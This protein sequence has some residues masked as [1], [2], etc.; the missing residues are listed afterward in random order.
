M[1]TVGLEA[2]ATALT[3]SWVSQVSLDP[4]LVMVAM[5]HDRFCNRVLRQGNKLAVNV[6]AEDQ[7]RLAAQSAGQ[8]DDDRLSDVPNDRAPDHWGA[9]ARRCGGLPGL[10]GDGGSRPWRSYA[11]H[12]EGRWE[13]S[14]ERR[15][16]SL[17]GNLRPALSQV[18]VEARSAGGLSRSTHGDSGSLPQA[19][20][21][22]RS[23]RR[24][25]TALMP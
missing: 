4:P 19:T 7:T 13:C 23:L 6:M 1:V 8:D 16:A 11:L 2:G 10:R 9:G 22:R 12:R 5:G 25:P 14:A 20:T 18:L 17:D 21:P 3:A 24:F 15:Q